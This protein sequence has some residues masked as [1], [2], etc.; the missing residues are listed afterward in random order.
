M[1]LQAV[2]NPSC[3]EIR[4][5]LTAAGMNVYVEVKEKLYCHWMKMTTNITHTSSG[6]KM[7][8][9]C[10]FSRTK[11]TPGSGTGTSS[12]E[13]VSEFRWSRRT[14]ASVRTSSPPVSPARSVGPDVWLR[15]KI[16]ALIFV[17]LS[18]IESK[19]G[20]SCLHLRLQAHIES[21]TGKFC[22]EPDPSPIQSLMW[23]F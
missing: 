5:V 4:D 19:L 14:A 18:L 6:L 2:E 8:S 13:V 10:V 3:A 9:L 16:H 20:S 17:Q 1:C 11:C 21:K 22:P 12:S 23:C 7:T 15:V